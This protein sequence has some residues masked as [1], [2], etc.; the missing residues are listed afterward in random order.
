LVILALPYCA[1]CDCAKCGKELAAEA[2]FCVFCGMPARRGFSVPS[3]RPSP[4]A[5]HSHTERNVVIASAL[6]LLVSIAVGS[7][8]ST[9]TV[10]PPSTQTGQA[11]WTTIKAFYRSENKD[12]E[13]FTVATNYWRIVYTISAEDEQFAAFSAFIYH[14]GETAGYVASVSLNRS[15]TEMSYV[16]AGPGDFYVSVLAANLRSWT[17]E[18]QIQQ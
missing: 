18:V 5:K 15:G 12:T 6:I 10:E 13:N 7:T 17:I 16:R 2:S 1:K 9:P 4:P 14:S 3:V 11:E 8:V